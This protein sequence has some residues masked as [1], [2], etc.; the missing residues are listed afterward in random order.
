MSSDP[1]GPCNPSSRSLDSE[2]VR[3]AFGFRWSDHVREVR[4]MVKKYGSWLNVQELEWSA[5]A[6][7]ALRERVGD[8]VAL[9][10]VAELW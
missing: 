6:R 3:F 5:L 10:G 9:A 7:Q 8:V 2:A 1:L 4:L